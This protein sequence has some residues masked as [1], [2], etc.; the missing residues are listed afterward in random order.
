MTS[1]VAKVL[2]QLSSEQK[3][4]LINLI[5][6]AIAIDGIIAS[7]QFTFIFVSIT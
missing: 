3:Q 6:Q 1:N 7:T 5:F 2:D 4:I